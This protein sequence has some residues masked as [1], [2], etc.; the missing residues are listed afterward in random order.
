MIYVTGDMHG[1]L[2]RFDAAPIR[3]LKRGDFLII[4]GDFGFLWDGDDAEQKALQ[5]LSKK[6]Y[7]ILFL[8]GVHENY[9]LLEKYPVEEW[10]GGK[11]RRIADNI[12]HLMR[13]EVFRLEGRLIFA[14]GG[15]EDPEKQFRVEAGKW[16]P[17]G[18]PSLAEMR[19]GVENLEKNNFA[20]DYILT[21]SPC[22]GVGGFQFKQNE[23]VLDMYLEKIEK[24]V[25]HRKWFFG[26]THINRH[27]TARCE[28]VFD[29]VFPLQ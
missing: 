24:S 26:S 14:F 28:S 11:V 6:K 19:N 18:T 2:R 9:D 12:L 20:V 22:P 7:N 25:R 4:C 21:H 8:D 16:W 23:S 13:G 1:D 5:K 27:Y 15:G 29:V 3:R 17:Q 10:N